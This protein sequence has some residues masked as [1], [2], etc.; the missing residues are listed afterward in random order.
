VR[1][2][3][4]LLGLIGIILLL[5]AGVAVALTRGETIFDQIYIGVH[6]AAGVLALI[7]YLSTGVENLRTFLGERSTKYG[8]S[9]VL[10]S[11]IFIAIL[12]ILNFLAYRHNH[13]FDLTSEKVFSLSPQSAQVLTGLTKDLR[14][15]AFVEGGANPELDD[16]LKNYGATS[17]KVSYRLVDPDREPEMAEKYGIKSY[18]TVRITYGEASNQVTQ[19]TEENLS[20]AIIKLT[21]SGKQTVCA[22]EGP[23]E[24][25]IDDKQDDPGLAQAAIG[26]Q[27]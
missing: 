7:A 26:G 22:I 13:R 24:P 9:T 15:E 21:R 16:L 6:G 27:N 8:T 25:D 20:N 14:M 23:G 12:A 1:R 11:L 19:P 17:S 5:F 3:N 18:N 2:S 10:A 4:G